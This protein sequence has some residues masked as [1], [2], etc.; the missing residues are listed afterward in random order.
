VGGGINATNG[1]LL[2]LDCIVADNPS[3]SDFY[4][5]FGALTDGGDNI[6]SDISFRFTAPGSM[7]NTNPELGLLGNYGGPTQTIPL[8]VG[9][10]A[11]DAGG[12]GGCPATD[13]RGV[14]RPSGGFCDIGA[15]EYAGFYIQGQVQSFGPT[16]IITVSAGNW[17]SVTDSRGN[18]LLNNVAAG[19]YPVTPSSSIPGVSFTPTNQILSVGPSATNVNFVAFLM[20][21]LSVEGYANRV[22]QLAFAGT[23]GQTE[24]VEISTNLINWIPV[25]TNV[26]GTNGILPFWLTNSI[27]QKAQFV[28]T[29]TP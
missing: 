21:S 23:N 18:Y 19:T 27:V 26:V 4:G 8:L 13:Q 28:R 2:L 15:F 12:A 22:L 17:S 24:V 3:G 10:P 20:N 25:S 5:T 29:R 14:S 7:N 9:S 16:G 11:M 6:S 1:S